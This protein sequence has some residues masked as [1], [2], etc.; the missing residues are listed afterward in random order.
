MR[1]NR[2]IG[3]I[4]LAAII[5]LALLAACLSWA[6][7]SPVGA[8]PDDDYHMASI[9]CGAGIK[10]GLC[11]EGHAAN[12]RR[13]PMAVLEASVC[14]AHAPEKS[15]SCPLSSANV[16][17]NTGRGNFADGGYPPVFYAV[18]SIFVTGDISASILM[19]RGFN[20]LLFVGFA[21]TLYFLLPWMR[22]SALL[23]GGFAVIVP[24]GMF[25]VPSVNPSS[26][27]IIS[28]VTLWV[29][30]LGYFQATGR[31][32]RIALGGL[33]LL[34]TLIGAGARADSA[35]YNG[36]AVVA[37][38]ALTIQRTRRYAL[39]SMLPVLMVAISIGFFFS[40]GQS[41]VAALNPTGAAPDLENTRRLWFYNS[42]HLPE[43][44]AGVL[45][46]WGLGWLDTAMPGSVWVLALAAAAGIV[47]WGL[48]SMGLRKALALVVV[49]FSLISIPLY[50]LMADQVLIGSYV[51]PRYIYPLVILVVGLSLVGNWRPDLGLTRL[52]LWLIAGLLS[53][54][55]SVALHTNLRRYITGLD[56]VEW[57]LNRWIE[58]WWSIPVSPMVLWFVGSMAF[59]VAIG[60]AVVAVI[61]ASERPI[62][63]RPEIAMTAA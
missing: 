52:Q 1:S 53:I 5:P 33:A 2:S 43:L 59:S 19:M 29:A 35:V 24:L 10:A 57:N 36:V 26:W 27:A 14:F 47:F 62:A 17:T 39:L 23:W 3:T 4:L 18:M 6:V 25:L 48:Q 9:W 21:T 55:N 11:E 13:V 38:I 34:A 51:Q 32:R 7:A 8:S 28:A 31:Q 50:I 22:R 12:E 37:V 44:W 58:W 60:G 16:L 56:A 20:A 46:T 63:E 41:D 30:L 45:G 42:L 15:A 61:G 49:V 40:S 54:A